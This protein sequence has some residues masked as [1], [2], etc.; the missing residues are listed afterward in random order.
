MDIKEVLREQ[1][2]DCDAEGDI[3]KKM[4]EICDGNF[5]EDSSA[6]RR[7]STQI[8]K[9]IDKKTKKQFD[10]QQNN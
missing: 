2:E 3:V 6:S 7:R 1:I 4:I 8:S 9:I 10:Q 5:T